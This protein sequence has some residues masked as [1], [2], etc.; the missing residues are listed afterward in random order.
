MLKT[1]SDWL[2]NRTGYKHL[3]HETLDE[4]VKGG[5][6]WRYVFGSAVTTAFMIQLLTGIFLM[7]AYSPSSST[8]WGSVYFI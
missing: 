7:T 1:L 6:R 8:A 4:P 3:I 5:A 2:D